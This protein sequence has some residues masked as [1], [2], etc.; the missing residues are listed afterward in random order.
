M[1]AALSNDLPDPDAVRRLHDLTGRVALVTGG[2]SGLGR[3]IAWG[4]ACHGAAV[5]IADRNLEGAKA[6]ATAIAEATGQRTLALGVDVA[7]EAQVERAVAQTLQALGGLDILLNGAGN[8]LR[9]P[10]LDF[11]QD[12]FESIL[13]V[14]LRGA[15]LFC[16]AAGRHMQEQRRGSIINVASIAG[17]VGIANVSPY[18]AAKGALVQLSRT[19]A[20][21]MASY[22][23]RVNAVSPGFVETPLTLQH[24][25]EVRRRIAEGTPLGRMGHASELI[26]PTVFLASDASSFVTGSALLVDGGWTAQ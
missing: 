25:P 3:S 24:A 26:G 9:K 1:A 23:V 20:L 17:H 14:H 11:S 4:F 2:A 7:Q 21:E 10:L 5:A 6:A 16:R 8:N 22:G 13:Q 19:L 12:E 15:F 18:A